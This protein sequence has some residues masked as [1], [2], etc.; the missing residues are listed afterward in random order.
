MIMT[1]QAL[2]GVLLIYF[3][4]AISY[5]FMYALAGHFYKNPVYKTSRIDKKLRT[6][7]F[8]PA[9]KEDMVILQTAKEAVELEYPSG[10]MDVWVIAD[11][12]KKETLQ[13]LRETGAKVIEVSFESSTKAKALN[14]AMERISQPYDVAF[15]LDAD[16]VAQKDSLLRIREAFLAGAQVVQC[17]RVAKNLESGFAVLDG[18]S[19]EINNHIF[20][21]GH[22]AIGLSSRLV[23]SG[24]AFEYELFKEVMQKIDAVGG[25]DKELELRLLR[26][27]VKFHYLHK[28]DVYDEKVSKAEVFARQ[29]TR[30]I[31]AQFHYAA[32]YFPNACW[33][34]I[35]YGK[36]DYFD[37]ALQM[38]LPP[39][40][41]LLGLVCL[42][43]GVAY[44][45]EGLSL[46][47]CVLAA[48]MLI[49]FTIS[50]PAYFFRTHYLNKLAL[51]P[52]AFLLMILAML[53][54]K[55]AN[56]TF[57]HTPHGEVD[58]TVTEPKHISAS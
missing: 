47:W 4:F 29:R 8:I 49:S 10:E 16:N 48:G 54:I 23:G 56:K 12:L 32:N 2:E 13:K 14:S 38:I 15:I 22:R 26:E 24:M 37:K 41:I 44:V 21:K 6:A 33:Q 43:G 3:A 40:L 11:S 35:R 55:G 45:W 7:V 51:L 17:H 18:I 30:W 58:P 57:Y 1:L 52:Y 5:L 28:V 9:Y 39:R 42:L 19:E 36:L 27:R 53:K 25:F 20:S 31:A 34:L 50:V 46:L